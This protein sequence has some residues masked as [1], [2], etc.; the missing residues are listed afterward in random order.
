MVN[1]EQTGVRIPQE[2]DER[3]FRFSIRRFREASALRCCRLTE[4]TDCSVP[5]SLRSRRTDRTRRIASTGCRC[6]SADR[7]SSAHI[8]LPSS[9]TI[10]QPNLVKI[11]C[12]NSETTVRQHS[13]SRR[14]RKRSWSPS[15]L[16][17]FVLSAACLWLPQWWWFRICRLIRTLSA[18]PRRT[19]ARRSGELLF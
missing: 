19:S 3:E 18:R 16:S 5:V 8:G 15:Q 11:D 12:P 2:R 7:L 1:W 4:R 6:R 9:A 14:T 10:G 13:R 17:P